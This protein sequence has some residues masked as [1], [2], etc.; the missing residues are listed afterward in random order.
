MADYLQKA[1]TI[2]DR[3]QALGQPVQ[4]ADL[5]EDIT[6]GLPPS[7]RPLVRSLH[8]RSVPVTYLELHGLL[9]SEEMDLA[10]EEAAAVVTPHANYAGRSSTNYRGRSHMT[11]GRGNQFFDA[12]YGGQRNNYPGQFPRGTYSRQQPPMQ[13]P[14]S[15]MVCYNCKGTGHHYK[16]CP[17]PRQI[18]QNPQA[19]YMSSPS[20][21]NQTWNIDSGATHHLTNDLQNLAL[22][23]EYQGTEHV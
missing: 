13:A 8:N 7:Y 1:K 9:I 6:H 11:R 17:S 19:N 12:G 23:S 3:L 20:N 4:E 10:M 16:M 21:P 5:V 18:P 14:Q 22:H 15:T 2:Y